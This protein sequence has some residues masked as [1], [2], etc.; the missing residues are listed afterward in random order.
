MRTWPEYGIS[1]EASS[2]PSLSINELYPQF[3]AKFILLIRQPDLVVN[4][5]WTKGWYAH[6]YVQADPDEALGYQQHPQDHH[7][8]SR[9]APS[10]RKFRTWNQM[11][12]MGKIGWFW[13]AINLAVVE[14]F[15]S[16][17]ETHWRIVKL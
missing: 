12:R 7:T 3:D 15:A 16:L 2:Y 17:P 5:Y 11:S 13:N 4:S 10:G 6:K 14:Q 9:I 8:L 1:F